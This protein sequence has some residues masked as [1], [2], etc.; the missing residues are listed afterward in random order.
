MTRSKELARVITLLDEAKEEIIE[1]QGLVPGTWPE[2]ASRA[3]SKITEAQNIL[4]GA[5]PTRREDN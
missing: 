2:G 3:H 5:D 4:V 1:I